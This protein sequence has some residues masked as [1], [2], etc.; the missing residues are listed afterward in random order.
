MN[1]SNTEYLGRGI[2]NDK[3]LKSLIN[4]NLKQMLVTVNDDDDLDTDDQGQVT[5]F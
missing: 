3:F 2:H 4:G 1:K 5:L